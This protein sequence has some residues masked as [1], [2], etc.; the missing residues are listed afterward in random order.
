MDLQPTTPT[1]HAIGGSASWPIVHWRLKEPS[2]QHQKLNIPISH[3]KHNIAINLHTPLLTRKYQNHH[4]LHNCLN[5]TKAG[6]FNIPPP[7]L[8]QNYHPL[9]SKSFHIP[10]I[11]PCYNSKLTNT[12][13]IVQ[14]YKHMANYRCGG[15]IETKS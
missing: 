12:N 14:C 6:N 10:L 1:F 8:P 15:K 9:P 3:Q 7:I 11:V 5:N 13:F 4:I 2:I